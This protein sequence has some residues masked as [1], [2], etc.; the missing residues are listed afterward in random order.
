MRKCLC[1][2]MCVRYFKEQHIFSYLGSLTDA[3]NE[4]MQRND[5][6]HRQSV[7]DIPDFPDTGCNYGPIPGVLASAVSV[8]SLPP[9]FFFPPQFFMVVAF[10]LLSTLMMHRYWNARIQTFPSGNITLQIRLQD[11][12]ITTSAIMSSQHVYTVLVFID[13]T[14]MCTAVAV[15]DKL[16]DYAKSGNAVS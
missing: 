8:F 6:D 11:I 2:C 4:C 3:R 13:S 12:P 15:E 5:R 10:P 9:L 16:V 1:F 7:F 14:G